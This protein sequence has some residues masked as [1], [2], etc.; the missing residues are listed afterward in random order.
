MY[1]ERTR[2]L[3][4]SR[5]GI[6]GKKECTAANGRLMEVFATSDDDSGLNA[7]L[8]TH[9]DFG[10]NQ[11]SEKGNGGFCIVGDAHVTA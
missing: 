8:I 7:G 6:N 10:C 1:W 11:Y 5:E 4:L 9:G 2:L 3:V